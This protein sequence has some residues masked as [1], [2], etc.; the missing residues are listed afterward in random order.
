M[1]AL[2]LATGRRP[3]EMRPLR[4]RG[5]TP[6]ILWTEGVLLVRRSETRGEVMERTKTGRRLRIPLPAA[7]LM[8]ILQHHVNTLPTGPMLESELLFPSLSGGYRAPSCLD[9]PIRQIARAAK[10]QKALTPRFMRRTFQD[11]GR[12]ASVHDFVVRPSRAT[13]RRRCRSTTAAS[14]GTRCARAWP[15]S[16]PW[17]A[18]RERGQFRP[19]GRHDHP[20][21]YAGGYAAPAFAS[22]IR[23]KRKKP[24]E[25]WFISLRGG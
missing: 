9:G 15:R 18:S 25:S 6:D 3:S 8:E 1:L 17:P 16:S 22:T 11:L 20:S 24:S 23:Q 12:A 2:G 5:P 19:G 21:G 4:R 10:I 13:P 14:A 7:E